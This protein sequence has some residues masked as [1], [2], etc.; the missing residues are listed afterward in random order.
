MQQENL[1][2][3]LQIENQNLLDKLY[4]F[5]HEIENQ[6]ALTQ[7]IENENKKLNLLLP[8]ACLFKNCSEREP[9]D[10]VKFVQN[11]LIELKK[12]REEIALESEETQNLEKERSDL[13]V[14]ENQLD[15]DLAPFRVKQVTSTSPRKTIM[16]QIKESAKKTVRGNSYRE[17]HRK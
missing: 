14:Y 3:K 9:T 4:A 7:S 2:Q 12:I 5:Q 17:I 1:T 6:N 13:L 10:E 15:K 11:I 8:F 16:Q